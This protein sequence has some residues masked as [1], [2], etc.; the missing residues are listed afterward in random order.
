[1]MIGVGSRDF[2]SRSGGAA[3]TLPSLTIF[4]NKGRVFTNFQIFYFREKVSA[5]IE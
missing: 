5:F 4:W 2:P 3:A 1:M